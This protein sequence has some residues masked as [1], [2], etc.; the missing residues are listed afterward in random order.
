MSMSQKDFQSL[1]YEMMAIRPE[2]N[3]VEN[4][5]VAW[6]VWYRAVHA[7]GKACKLANSSF[8]MEKFRQAC[9]AERYV[10]AMH[11]K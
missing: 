5:G 9:L 7:I 11:G 8:D 3:A 4:P 1:A 2:E 6:D 10:P